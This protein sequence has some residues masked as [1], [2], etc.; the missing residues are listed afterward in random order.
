MKMKNDP[1]DE[2]TSQD[3]SAVSILTLF[4]FLNLSLVSPLPLRECSTK[5]VGYPFK[6]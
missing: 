5:A 6:I 4:F 3:V 1:D 2:L